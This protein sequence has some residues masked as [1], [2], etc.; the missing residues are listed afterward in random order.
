MGREATMYFVFAVEAGGVMGLCVWVAIS[1][2]VSFFW[3]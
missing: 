1:L 2:L 3:N